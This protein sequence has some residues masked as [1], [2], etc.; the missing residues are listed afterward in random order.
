MSQTCDPEGQIPSFTKKDKEDQTGEEEKSDIFS[1]IEEEESSLMEDWISQQVKVFNCLEDKTKPDKPAI[2][3]VL[4]R[5]AIKWS[6]T[7]YLEIVKL[8]VKFLDWEDHG[9]DIA[10]TLPLYG[11]RKYLQSQRFRTSSWIT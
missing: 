5:L 7:P 6:G 1:S 11:G 10:Y 3:E 2:A 8:C 4:K 9:N